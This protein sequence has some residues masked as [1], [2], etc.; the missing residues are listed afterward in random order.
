MYRG[1]LITQLRLLTTVLVFVVLAWNSL[2][3]VAAT[4]IEPSE[5]GE[6]SPENTSEIGASQLIIEGTVVDSQ[7]TPA[8]GVQ[9]FVPR[10]MARGSLDVSDSKGQFK[11]QL[12]RNELWL[13]RMGDSIRVAIVGIAHDDSLQAYVRLDDVPSSKRRFTGV[14]LELKPARTV[15][16]H[17]LNSAKQ[18][19]ADARVVGLISHTDQ[20]F[21]GLSDESGRLVAKVPADVKIST[22]YA[23]KSGVGL[24]Y[25]N[26]W[27]DR[28]FPRDK[29]QTDDQK[30]VKVKNIDQSVALVLS[31][32]RT[33]R[34]LA[35]D[36]NEKPIAGLPIHPKEITLG[37]FAKENPVFSPL[38]T[39]ELD[40]FQVLTDKDGIA[41]FNFM[42]A[43]FVTLPNLKIQSHKYWL[44]PESQPGW[45]ENPYEPEDPD[46]FEI[47]DPNQVFTLKLV[48]KRKVAGVVRTPDGQPA[49]NVCVMLS[50]LS[51]DL[52]FH[53]DGRFS[54][55][56]GEFTFYVPPNIEYFLS[57]TERGWASDRYSGSTSNGTPP[58]KTEVILRSATRVFGRVKKTHSKSST[59]VNGTIVL[60]RLGQIH[61]NVDTML[62][63]HKRRRL[64]REYARPMMMQTITPDSNG[65]FE[66]YV[67]N[68]EYMLSGPSVGM[69]QF[70]VA[71]EV[72]KELN[73]TKRAPRKQ[74]K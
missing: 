41:T 66:V 73:L 16:V 36:E 6:A 42:P 46:D 60:V 39:G 59:D 20:L 32:F 56:R 74:K 23:R 31:P 64:K 70:T 9:I 40:E 29:E 61:R 13:D 17:V 25:N 68:G 54:N 63:K 65:N 51:D 45:R 62:K 47:P 52:E 11:L 55:D 5:K 69:K 8:A 67:G 71:G 27:V 48:K 2:D 21:S 30:K 49:A 18:A 26:L 28:S 7:G 24:N 43:Q 12:D 58:K 34:V 10:I 37:N 44:P 57:A 50:G 15:S 38:P 1:R 3:T 14:R 72:E 35:V 22:I 19:V 53:H 4:K 33:V